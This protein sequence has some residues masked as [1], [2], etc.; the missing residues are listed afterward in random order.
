RR[1]AYALSILIIL[2]GLLSLAVKGGPSLGIDFAGG[3]IMQVELDEQ[4]D[5]GQLSS[6]LEPQQLPSLVVQRFSGQEGNHF[7]L[8]ISDQGLAPAQA[9]E[10]VQDSLEQAFGQDSFEILRLEMVGPKVGADL[11]ESALKAL[12]FALLFIAIYISG[13]FE[14]KW[15]VSAFMAAG[16]ALGVYLLQLLAVPVG[17]LIAAAVLITLV[18]CWYLKLNYALGAVTALIH[19]MLIVVGIFSLLNREFDLSIVAALLT[20]IGYSLNDTI[21]VFDRIR[22]NLRSKILPTLAETINKSI[23]QTLSRTLITSGTTLLVVLALLFFGG[24]IINDFAFALTVG[25]LVGT[26]SS[27]YVASPVLL[28]FRPLEED[29]EEEAESRTRPADQAG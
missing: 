1:P 26:Y 27:I 24:G 17:F 21:I 3:I 10:A 9:R 23:N 16:L 7:L 12:F 19:D 8:R 25:V 5:T 20:I 13:R 6:V 4:V 14:Q 29:E 15:F 22:E 11:R 18:L 2:I 28:S